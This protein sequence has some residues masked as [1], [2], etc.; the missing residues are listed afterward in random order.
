MTDNKRRAIERKQ[1]LI[2]PLAWPALVVIGLTDLF[3]FIQI[4]IGA[5]SYPRPLRTD[6]MIDQLAGEALV[7]SLFFGLIWLVIVRRLVVGWAL[8]RQDRGSASHWH[9]GWR[10]FGAAALLGL[11]SLAA[12]FLAVWGFTGIFIR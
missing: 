6:D 8:R 12:I 2:L 11:V 9:G 3:L 10:L 4:N 1:K 7:L 5:G